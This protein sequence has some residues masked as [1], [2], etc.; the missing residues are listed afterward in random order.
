ML[1]IAAILTGCTT[2]AQ[3]QV[4]EIA[5]NNGQTIPQ[6][7]FGTYSLIKTG[8]PSVK[9]AIQSGYR[10]FDSAQ[11]YQNEAA[12]Y[13]GVIE[14]G[15]DRS[16]AFIITKISPSN[17]RNGT[18][19]ESL[20]KSLADLGGEYIDLVLIHWPVKEHIKE[21][22]QIMEEYVDKG[23]VKA[24]G[25]SNFNPH[26]IDS[27]LI[28]AR[29]KPVLNQIEIH[30]YMTQEENVA[31]TRSKGIAV[32]GWSPLASGGVLGDPVIGSIAER[33]GKSPAQIVIRWHLQR[34]LITIPRSDN[35]AYIA[36]NIDV[37]GFELTERDMATIS[38]LNR[39]E[40]TYEQN[41]P[42]TFPW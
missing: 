21:T 18:V 35:P 29:I 34:D 13:Q 28:Y 38:A 11:D 26:H 10:M 22:W 30:P 1:A 7:G 39:N 37:F 19:R 15:I 17:M 40:R 2:T 14:S 27:L 41:D 3:T 24:I 5:L 31:Y 12:V 33:Y 42:D 9:A 32:Q 8:T 23:V 6:L 16:K 25:L 20:D 4:P 36:E